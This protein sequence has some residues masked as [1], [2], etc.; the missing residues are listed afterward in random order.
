MLSLSEVENWH[1][2]GFFV[3]RGIALE[4]LF[5]ELIVL[6]G[7]LERNASIILWRIAVL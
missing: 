1:H 4:D 5:D 7:E 3:L 6:L 2:G